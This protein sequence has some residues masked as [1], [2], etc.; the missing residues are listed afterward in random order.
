MD[1]VYLSLMYYGVYGLVIVAIVDEV[2]DT[3]VSIG[4]QAILSCR[5]SVTATETVGFVIDSNN[6]NTSEMKCM[7]HVEC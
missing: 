4:Q 6:I 5:A 1:K 3:A 7:L 2:S